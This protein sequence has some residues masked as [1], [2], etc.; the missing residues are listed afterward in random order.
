MGQQQLLLLVLGIVIVGLAVVTGIQAFAENQKKSNADALVMTSVR[1]AVEAQAWLYTPIIRGGGLP[2]TGGR[3]PD[4]TGLTLDLGIMGYPVDGSNEYQDIYGT[5]VGV[6]DGADF[7]ITA[8]SATSSGGGDN[9]LVCVIVSDS[10]KS[11][12]QT[13][14]NPTSGSCS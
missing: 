13:I 1:F 3:P 9:N 5:Y 14:I 8:T 6:V 10:S 7:V 12:I 2:A 4:F 11:G